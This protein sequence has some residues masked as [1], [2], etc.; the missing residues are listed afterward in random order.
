MGLRFEVFFYFNKQGRRVESGK[1]PPVRKSGLV[2]PTRNG[3]MVIF[4]AVKIKE[5]F[6]K[7]RD[8]P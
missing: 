6:E 8:Y 2:Q 7:E 3:K 1:L 4:S 5:L